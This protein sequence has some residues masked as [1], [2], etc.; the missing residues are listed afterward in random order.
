MPADLLHLVML[1]PTIVRQLAQAYIE[2]SQALIRW[3][4]AFKAAMGYPSGGKGKGGHMGAYPQI[5]V[6][7]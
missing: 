3:L 5:G 6:A 2:A 4:L 1:P 7:R